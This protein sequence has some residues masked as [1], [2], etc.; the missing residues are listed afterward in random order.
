MSANLKTL[1]EA[2]RVAA[3]LD[4]SASDPVWTT[5]MISKLCKVAPRTVS[6]WFDSGRL[7]GYRVPDSNDRRVR[8]SDLHRFLLDH[9]MTIEAKRV[10]PRRILVI[11]VESIHKEAV[12]ESGGVYDL[13]E[14]ECA[15][16]AFAAGLAAA[17]SLWPVIVCDFASSPKEVAIVA[18][19]LRST[20]GCERSLLLALLGEDQ[21]ESVLPADARFD[22][23][24]RRPFDN[25]D[26]SAKL[27]KALGLEVT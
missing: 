6:K 5:G 8:Q 15:V 12:R 13:V 3:V 7:P 4:R 24:Y 22:G 23:V 18:S 20:T 1:D 2:R 26:F 10:A 16:D 27:A 21:D 9:H 14:K 25:D 17:S 19:Q 11:G